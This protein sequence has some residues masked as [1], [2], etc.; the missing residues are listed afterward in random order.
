MPRTVPPPLAAA[1]GI[2]PAV[3]DGVRAL[4]AKAVH[5]PFLALS[6]TLVAVGTVRREYDDLVD[7]GERLIAKLRGVSVDE[8]EDRFEDA[9][10]DTPLAAAYERVED[11]VEEAV[12]DLTARA[13]R[14]AATVRDAATQ[15][16][17][18]VQE[19]KGSAT[20]KASQPDNTRIDTAATPEVVR[21]ADRAAARVDVDEHAELPLPDYDHMTLGALRG[22]L[23]SLDVGQLVA[24]RN[25]E[26]AHADRLPVVTMLD[27]RIAKL[28]TDAATPAAGPDKG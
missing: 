11:A 22:K 21:A 7:R 25:Y 3:A 2:V 19:S 10:Q 1:I 24:L 5:A 17:T 27:N 28:A 8:L 6:G 13:S 15:V 23:R 4:P 9:L 14:T 16:S 18:P 20:P 26:K 12:D